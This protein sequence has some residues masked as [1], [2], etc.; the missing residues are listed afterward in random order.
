MTVYLNKA[1]GRWMYNFVRN[2]QRHA[3]Y[4]VDPASGEPAKTKTDAK[5]IEEVLK[6]EAAKEQPRAVPAGAFTLAQ[7]FAA[8]A[9]RK[10]GGKNWPNETVYIREMLA[11][12]G[13]DLPASEITE[14]RIWEYVAWSREQPVMIYV[15]GSKK[16]EPESDPAKLYRPSDR[17]RADSTINRYLI[18]LGE[19]LRLVHGLKDTGGRPLLAELPKVPRLA[20]PEHLPRPVSDDDLQA[21]MQRVPQH[22]ADGILLARL[23]GFRKGE[24]FALT[25]DQVDFQNRG[26]WLEA[27]STKANRA[28]FISAGTEAMEVLTRLVA[29]ARGWKQLHLLTY[30]RGEK[31]KRLPVK[32]P[33]RAWQTA[34]KALG[35]QYRFHDTKASYVTAVA[36]VATAA[37]TQQLARHRSYET[38]KRYLRVAD[39]AARNAVEAI[40]MKA[41]ANAVA[42]PS[43]KQ[44]SQTDGMAATK[45]PQEPGKEKALEPLGSKAFPLPSEMVGA[46][47]FEPATLRPPV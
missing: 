6:V 33:K 40:P 8:L 46:T 12:F 5:R 18:C 2:G 27:S 30:Q 32:N 34:M 37:V 43:R 16:R 14:Q 41:I 17:K 7:T 1:R 13:A 26:V 45:A 38:T 11:W 25:V 10:R 9:T 21:I 22:L 23:M 44:E 42:S 47:G 19:A 36:H 39:Q 4:C 24:V 15:G 28:E 35:L 3:G 31:G 29:Q 20:E